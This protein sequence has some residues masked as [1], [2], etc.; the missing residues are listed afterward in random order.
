[1]CTVSPVPILRPVLVLGIRQVP[2][3]YL[4]IECYLFTEF[5]K[6][7]EKMCKIVP[8]IPSPHIYL[9]YLLLVRHCSGC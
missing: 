7:S 9:L 3:T 8:L 5:S 1:M 4:V 2:N 6:S